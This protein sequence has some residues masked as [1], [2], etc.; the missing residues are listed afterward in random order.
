LA[1]TV[2]SAILFFIAIFVTS[3]EAQI[4]LW[5]TALVIDVVWEVASA[6]LLTHTRIQGHSIP[7]AIEHIAERFGPSLVV[8]CRIKIFF[9]N[10]ISDFLLLL[11]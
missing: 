8:V 4:W 10:E 9:V 5:S 2:I 11:F 1:G 3:L 6:W 7:Y